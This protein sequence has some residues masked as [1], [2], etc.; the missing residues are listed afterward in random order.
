MEHPKHFQIVVAV[1]E[2]NGIG[3]DG[4]L[5]WPLLKDDLNYFKRLTSD[6]D[7]KYLNAVIMGMK[8]WMSLPFSSRPLPNRLNI[9]ITKSPP[10]SFD[11]CIF[12]VPTLEKALSL[13]KKQNIFV[14]GGAQLY[15]EAITSKWCTAI[16]MT[17]IK[18]TFDCDRFFPA[19]DPCWK[20][21]SA[22]TDQHDKNTG[23]TYQFLCYTKEDGLD[24]I[25]KSIEIRHDEYQYLDLVRE[26]IDKG[27]CRD[28]R[29]GTG[30]LSVFGRQMRFNLRHSFPLLT[31]KRVF[32][33]GVVEELL[34]FIRG[35]TNANHLAEKGV[36][37]WDGNGSREYLDS[38]G[39]S[40]REQGDLGPVY[41]FQWRHYGAEYKDM[42]TDYK[43]KGFD[44]LA[45]L[46]ERIKKTPQ[47]RRLIL[48]AWNV[49]SLKDMALPPCHMT[50]QFYVANGELS[51]Q[52]YQRSADIGLGVPFNIASYSLLTY[53]MAQV[54]GLKPGDFVHVLGDAHVY[55][56]HVEP[57]RE[58]LERTVRPFPKLIMN[59]AKV[60]IDEFDASDFLLDGYRPHA[61]LKMQMAV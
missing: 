18:A 46:I 28:D 52:L 32:W 14:I 21:W 45:D 48:T 51:C 27:V 57:L 41:G 55:L 15:A 43:G 34:W 49:D 6:T 13:C 10:P 16:H 8:T 2:Q 17:K 31:T 44:Q 24:N 54:C 11:P 20:V 26:V 56:N 53:M 60:D 40:H 59:A 61:T 23:L 36:R 19:L 29:T 7:G 1:D 5:P 58:Q 33:K 22:S 39:M 50:C 47:D 25:P 9:I 35:D 3:K 38:I 4:D 30:T 37:I 12:F 42:H